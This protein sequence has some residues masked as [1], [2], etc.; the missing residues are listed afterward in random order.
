MQITS[1][2]PLVIVYNDLGRINGGLHIPY[3]CYLIAEDNRGKTLIID[4]FVLDNLVAGMD[5]GK[6]GIRNFL[7]DKGGYKFITAHNFYSDK[8]IP[9]IA[10]R[11]DAIPII[12]LDGLSKVKGAKV[13][14]NPL[15]HDKIED[16]VKRHPIKFNNLF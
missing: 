2:T 4:E 8:T 6:R 11:M 12:R 10:D 14:L 13:V 15:I 16:I 1:I 9:I 3:F 7:S 5:L